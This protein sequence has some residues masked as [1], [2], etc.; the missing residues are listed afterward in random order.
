MIHEPISFSNKSGLNPDGKDK[1]LSIMY[2]TPN[3]HQEVTG[4]SLIA[5]SKKCNTNFK[6]SF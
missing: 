5:A 2:R 6:S 4:A 3:M 1:S